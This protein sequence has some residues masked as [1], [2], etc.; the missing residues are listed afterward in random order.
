[1]ADTIDAIARHLKE[2]SAAFV[3]EHED[4]TNAIEPIGSGAGAR[5]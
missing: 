3:F 5:Q 2:R 4:Q 1:M